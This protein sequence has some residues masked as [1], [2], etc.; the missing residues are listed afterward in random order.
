MSPV[1]C[2]KTATLGSG[3]KSKFVPPPNDEAFVGH[4]TMLEWTK[5][6]ML[7]PE[8][9]GSEL[10]SVTQGVFVLRVGRY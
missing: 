10:V 2:S 1:P 3:G 9:A 4:W 8:S 6:V 7:V 5:N